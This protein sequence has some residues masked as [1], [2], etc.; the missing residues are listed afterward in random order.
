MQVKN[1]HD[2]IE[3]LKAENIRYRET[4]RTAEFE[5][6][7]AALQLQVWCRKPPPLA[8]EVERTALPF[9]KH[10]SC[11]ARWALSLLLSRNQAGML[12]SWPSR[13]RSRA[14]L[15][16]TEKVRMTLI[17]VPNSTE[18]YPQLPCRWRRQMRPEW[19]RSRRRTSCATACAAT[20]ASSPP[21]ASGASLWPLDEFLPLNRVARSARLMLGWHSCTC[22]FVSGSS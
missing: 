17:L 22:T 1:L 2:R 18:A 9:A 10:N 7:A 3:K 13:Q 20:T 12:P 16:N 21:T 15:R 8:S 14:A 6:A 5:A 4:N 11:S 19:R